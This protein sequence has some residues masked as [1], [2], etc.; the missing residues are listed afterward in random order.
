MRE[1]PTGT[2]TCVFEEVEGSRELLRLDGQDVVATWF[3]AGKAVSVE[4]ATALALLSV[5]REP[6]L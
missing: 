1:L 3:A 2:V 5:G 4:D 6:P